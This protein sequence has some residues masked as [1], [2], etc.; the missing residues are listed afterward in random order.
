MSVDEGISAQSIFLGATE[1]GFGGCFL[2]NIQREKLAEV[3]EL[4]TEHFAISMVIA[5][6]VPKEEVVIEPMASDGDFKYWRDE[7][8]VH[9]VPKRSQEEVLL[10]QI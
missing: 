3:L 6:G 5:L 4:D 1:M 8:Q 10:K 2:M 7:K 9:H